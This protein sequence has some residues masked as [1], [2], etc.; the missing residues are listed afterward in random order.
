MIFIDEFGEKARRLLETHVFV[1]GLTTNPTILKKSGMS[2]ERAIWV[3][4]GLRGIHFVQVSLTKKEWIEVLSD[5]EIPREKFVVKIPWDP[6]PASEIAKIVKDLGYRF[7]ATAVYSYGQLLSAH[8]S[9]ADFAAVYYDRM[10]RNG[11]DPSRIL[12]I[13]RYLEIEVLVA[14]LKRPEQVEKVVEEGARHITLPVDVFE[15][16]FAG[17]FPEKDLEIFEGD[18]E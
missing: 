10:L 9:G 6:G 17:V 1:A 14:S 8:E 3:L 5:P 18:F 2:F 7:C 12:K 16:F 13:A 15:E 11:M 4:K